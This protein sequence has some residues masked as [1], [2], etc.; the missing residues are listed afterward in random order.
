MPGPS[1]TRC[2]SPSV[3]VAMSVIPSPAVCRPGATVT[4]A[5]TP[6]A[7]DPGL[8]LLRP[9]PREP[10]ADDEVDLLHHEPLGYPLQPL[11][12]DLRDPLAWPGFDL[13]RNV[14]KS[15]LRID[16]SLLPNLCV[17]VTAVLQRAHDPLACAV[18][19]RHTELPCWRLQCGFPLVGPALVGRH[20]VPHPGE[21]DGA[22]VDRRAFLHDEA[23]MS[24]RWRSTRLSARRTRTSGGSTSA[25]RKPSAGIH[26]LHAPTVD[27][28]ET[29]QVV[30]PISERQR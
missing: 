15:Q 9:L 14:G 17:R 1:L 25:S 13:E 16:P 23:N 21:L 2:M 24:A 29:G 12:L 8:N 11:D 22:H 10:V 7:V 4:V 30:G 27:L 6:M 19:R 3:T 26:L 18:Q 5:N 20:G 28:V